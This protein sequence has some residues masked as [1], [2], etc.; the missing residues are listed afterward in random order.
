MRT[1]F[2]RLATPRLVPTSTSLGPGRPRLRCRIAERFAWIGFELVSVL[3]CTDIEVL[4]V[5]AQ[6]LITIRNAKASKAC[7][8]AH[9]F[10]STSASVSVSTSSPNES[11]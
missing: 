3:C 2:L 10:T 6:Q 9:L 7:H 11:E 4:S 8:V 5:I 1:S